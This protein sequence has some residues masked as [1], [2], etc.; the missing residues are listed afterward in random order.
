MEAERVRVGVEV[1]ERR[2]IRRKR[3][4]IHIVNGHRWYPLGSDTC[5][6][7]VS[8]DTFCTL[9]GLHLASIEYLIWI[10]RNIMGALRKRERMGESPWRS[11]ELDLLVRH[12]PIITATT[13]YLD[14]AITRYK[15]NVQIVKEAVSSSFFS[16][17]SLATMNDLSTSYNLSYLW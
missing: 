17:P 9:Y 4:G 6:F 12:L 16:P 8:K 15:S 11:T 3:S 2:W 1:Q 14:T 10:R 7:K 5:L 13:Y